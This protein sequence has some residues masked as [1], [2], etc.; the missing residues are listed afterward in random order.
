MA[1]VPSARETFDSIRQILRR[2][3]TVIFTVTA[4]C[5][6]V[7][8]IYLLMA[9]RLYRATASL[10]AES[11]AVRQTGSAIDMAQS[12]NFLR[13]QAERIAS[14][15]ILALALAN[16]D[17]KDLKTFRNS[18][19]RLTAIRDGLTIDVGRVNDVISVSFDS[20]YPEEAP[21]IANAVVQAYK[22]YQTEPV[23]STTDDVLSVY[24][25]QID[26]YHKELDATTARMA[27]M[28]Q[29]YGVL[30]STGDSSGNVNLQRLSTL[31]QELT[32]AQLETVKAKSD[33]DEASKTLPK[34]LPDPQASEKSTS[35]RPL[36]VSAEQEAA[37]R[38]E[39]IDLESRQQAMRQLYL[40]HHPALQAIGQQIQQVN[41]EY[42]GALEQHWLLA[43]KREQDM[44]DAFDAQQKRVIQISAETAEYERFGGDADRVRKSIDNLESR[45]QA[46]QV[47]RETDSVA[48]DL[49][50]PAETAILSHPRPISTLSTTLLL[51]LMLGVG[52][53]LF[54]EWMDDR[55]RSAG[56]VRSATGLRILGRVPSMPWVL[57]LSVA[58]QKVALDPAS[59]V[60]E[61][62]R[63][64]RAAVDSAAPRERCRTILITSAGSTDG[65]TTSAANL[66]IAMAQTGKR[67][68]LVDAVLRDPM[69][70][71]VFGVSPNSGLSTLLGSQTM[72]PEKTIRKTVINGLWVLP[73]GLTPHSPTELLNGPALASL[74]DDLA[75]KYDHV[76]ID[77]PPLSDLP[78]A[79]IIAASCDLTL[80]VVR[81]D[82]AT[83][84]Q[85]LLARDGLMGVGAHI[86]GLIL[87]RAP[88]EPDET[89]AIPAT[90]R[91]RPILDD[92][93]EEDAIDISTGPT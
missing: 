54:R 44:Q 57:N 7:A 89:T 48:V 11:S 66:A 85:T 13:T 23:H 67:V 1:R 41:R 73:A 81:A 12:G 87:T 58:A 63:A 55:M 3:Y 71:V 34:Q 5:F 49:L 80:L 56:D 33:F 62:Y 40:P 90:H 38:S 37:L 84:R 83:R 59:D 19:N 50:D 28:E 18:S 39:L 24:Q 15:S 92:P 53:A 21:L 4:L 51:G 46:I 36:I 60:A 79:R 22:Q 88:R 52:G 10:T 91:K 76:I 16:P 77:A 32:T 47:T 74:L 86:L 6:V 14:R 68:L 26:A 69:V 82:T 65:K 61:A 17:I 30:A 72:A 25:T 64:I 43:Q 9:T 8:I 42:V 75:D 78:D 93:S 35:P 20:R 70:H 27:A 45:M 31:S 29:Q 2:Q